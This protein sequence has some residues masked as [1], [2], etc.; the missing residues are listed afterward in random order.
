[1]VDRVAVRL[2]E[3]PVLEEIGVQ[4]RSESMRVGLDNVR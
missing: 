2:C 3:R 1:M 4:L